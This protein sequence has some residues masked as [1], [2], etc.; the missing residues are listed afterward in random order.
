MANLLLCLFVANLLLCLFVANLLLCLFVSGRGVRPTRL[1]Q[2]HGPN[3]RSS[4]GMS[5]APICERS[6]CPRKDSNLQPLVCRTSAP[7][8]ELLRHE[9]AVG[10]GFEPTYRAFQTRANPPQLSDPELER[11]VRIELTLPDLQSGALSTWL[12]AR[13]GTEGEVRTLESSLED[14]H[15]SSYITSVREHGTPGRIRT[16]N[17]DVRSV[18]PFQ[19]GHRSKKFWCTVPD[20]NRCLSVGNA[21]SLT[22]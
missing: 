16:R 6:W 3:S 22:G 15:V 17:L 4:A 5:H 19:L 12:R 18:A 2:L 7:S 8:V 10:V 20:S 14:S 21:A 11:A 13:V 1:F 9:L